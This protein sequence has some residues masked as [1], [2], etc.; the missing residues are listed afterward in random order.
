MLEKPDNPPVNAPETDPELFGIKPAT[1]G[2]FLFCG[3]TSEAYAIN[4]RTYQWGKGAH[5]TWSLGFSRLGS[6]GEDE[7]KE[8]YR[9]CF[10]EIS[11]ACNITHEYVSN[12]R[13]A[14]I[15]T[16]V[17]RLD[18]R[19]G[20]LADMQIPVGNVSTDRT[21]LLG[22]MDDSEQWGLWDNPP[23]GG[24]D[25]YR[26]ALHELLHAHGLGHKPASIREPALIA[27]M[28]DRNI[29]HLQAADI[30]ELVRRYGPAKEQK[31]PSKPTP[32]PPAGWKW[33]TITVAVPNK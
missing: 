26:V 18:G 3:V 12:H 19:G 14:N 10:A 27:P 29:R 17:Q 21:Q 1:E 5:L 32:E 30:K 33:E 15:L 7:L 24:I 13:T 25:L 16:N 6:L 20:T 9:Q 11:A 31:P 28:Y 2:G 22:R 4:G 23:S 8:A